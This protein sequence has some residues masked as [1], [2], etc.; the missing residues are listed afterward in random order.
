MTDETIQKIIDAALKVF[1]EKGYKGAT[2]RIIAEKAGFSELTLFRKF[3]TKENLFDVALTQNIIKFK[4]EFQ[5]IMLEDKS[6]NP[7]EFLKSIIIDMA[8]IIDDNFEFIHIINNEMRGSPE[9]FKKEIIKGLSEHIKKNI[10]KDKIDY[11]TFALTIFMVTYGLSLGKNRGETFINYEENLD[12]FI[13]NSLHC[14]L[15]TN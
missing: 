14:I 13:N 9:P 2:T 3:K 15:S 4:D 11:D 8:G 5:S 12:G 6:E 7:D 10:Q 1:G